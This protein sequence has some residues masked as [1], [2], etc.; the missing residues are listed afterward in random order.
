[1]IVK[2]TLVFIL[3]LG[4][5]FILGKWLGSQKIDEPVKQTFNVSLCDPTK[6]VCEFE[7]KKA[8]FV[9]EF[10]GTPSGLVPFEVSVKSKTSQPDSIELS[11]EMDG[12]DM[13]YNVYN[14][15]KFNSD[16]IAEV[17]LPVC[18]L[19]R[20]D[21]LMKVKLVLEEESQVTVFKFTQSD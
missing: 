14:L 13:G 17:I 15:K 5:T 18:S 12:M 11:F 10:K 3:I 16:W 21:W 7:F 4:F 1:M 20:N 6:N 19:G 9:L 2:A 8:I